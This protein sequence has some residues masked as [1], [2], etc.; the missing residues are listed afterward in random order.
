LAHVLFGAVTAGVLAM[1]RSETPDVERERFRSTMLTMMAGM[2]QVP[3]SP[4]LS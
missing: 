3:A 2:L 1:A 4:Q